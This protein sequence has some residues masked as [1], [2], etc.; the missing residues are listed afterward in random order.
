M[1]DK[2]YVIRIKSEINGEVMYIRFNCRTQSTEL[3][4]SKKHA[5]ACSSINKALTTLNYFLLDLH[6][7]ITCWSFRIEIKE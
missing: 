1:S 6:N 3:T 5:M 7:E 2:K 4:Y